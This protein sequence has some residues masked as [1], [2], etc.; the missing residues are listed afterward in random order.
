MR[1]EEKPIIA[2]RPFQ[3]S[4]K[5]VKPNLAFSLF[6]VRNVRLRSGRVDVNNCN[7]LLRG[8][9]PYALKVPGDLSMIEIDSE[10][11]MYHGQ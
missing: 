10:R 1:A 2:K 3:F 6:M 9:Q 8:L 5:A 7:R 4:A 11:E